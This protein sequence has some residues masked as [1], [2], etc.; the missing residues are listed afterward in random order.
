MGRLSQ[1]GPFTL[2]NENS[3][4]TTTAVLIALPWLR[5]KRLHGNDAESKRHD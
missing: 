5:S 4:H 1:A 2:N 3:D